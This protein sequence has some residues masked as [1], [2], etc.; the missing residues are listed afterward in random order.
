MPLEPHKKATEV[1]INEFVI[2]F[3]EENKGTRALLVAKAENGKEYT[4]EYYDGFRGE[5]DD[6]VINEK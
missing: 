6:L 1:K 3:T 4:F 5:H 2:R